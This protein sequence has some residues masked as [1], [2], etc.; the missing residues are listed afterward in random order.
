MKGKIW[1]GENLVREIF[2]R[3]IHLTLDE[4]LVQHL[5]LLCHGPKFEFLGDF[6]LTLLNIAHS[7]GFSQPH[8]P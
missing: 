6:F 3:R 2:V 1:E 5:L 8:Q 4:M 7:C